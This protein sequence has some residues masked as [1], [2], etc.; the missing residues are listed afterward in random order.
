LDVVRNNKVSITD[1]HLRIN[2]KHIE[3]PFG[4]YTKPEVYY[5]NKKGYIAITETQEKKVFLYNFKGK[6]Y[7]G[8][9][10]YGASSAALI[11]IKKS[12]FMATKENDTK[13][14][15]YRIK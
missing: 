7:K 15:V 12:V 5:A 13:V 4:I 3:L 1:N 8:F 11:A 9:P 10:V 6:L 14:L 2:G